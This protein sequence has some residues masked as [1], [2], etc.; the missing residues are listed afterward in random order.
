MDDGTLN[1]VPIRTPDQRLRVFVSST[2]EELADER[3]A[4][5]RA[6]S[7]LRLTPVM[8]ES[9]ARPHVP[10][11]LYQAYLAQSDI[12]IGLYWER[13]GWVAPE[14]AVSG[15]EDEFDLSSSLPRL[16]YIR[17][18]APDRD[19]RLVDLI[20]RIAQEASYRTFRTPTELGRL[21]RDDLATLLSERFAAARPAAPAPARD[22]RRLPVPTT[23]LVGRD[24]DLDDIAALIGGPGARLV[25]LTGPPGI[26]KT[27]LAIAAGQRVGDRF[28]AGAV[29]GA[30]SGVTEPPRA[31]NAIG[32]AVGADLT[33][34]DSPLQAL[35]ERIH[36]ESCLL[37]L[38]NLE[39]VRDVAVDLNTVLEACPG[40]AMLATSLI[41][42]RLRAEREYPVLPLPVRRRPPPT[43]AS[44]ARR[45][46]WRCS[47]IGLAPC[48]P[49]SPSPLTTRQRWWRSAAPGG[50]PARDRA[51][52][53]P[54][55]AAE[56]GF[57]PAP[58]GRVAGRGGQGHRRHAR[59]PPD[60]AGDRRVERRPARR[61][62]TIVA[63]G[64]RRV[65]R[66]LDGRRRRRGGRTPGGRRPRPDRRTGSA[67]PHR[68]RRH[69]A[70]AA[71]PDARD[72]PSLRRRVSGRPR[73]R[74]GYPAP[75]RR[76]L[77]CAHRAG[78][79]ARTPHRPGRMDR[80]PAHRGRE[81]G[82]VSALAP[83]A[84][85]RGPANL[86]RVLT[87]FWELRDP[88]GDRRGWIA[89]LR[90]DADSL[91][92]Q[93]RAELLWAG[94]MSALD[95]GDGSTSSPPPRR[96]A[97]GSPCS[98]P[99][100]RLATVPLIRW[101]WPSRAISTWHATPT[102]RARRSLSRH[103]STSA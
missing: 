80:A 13:Y 60:P 44:C 53:G 86:F 67:Q 96:S 39:D 90:P 14:S 63:R 38:D 32:R 23:S 94:A 103:A 45:P 93:P 31:V 10:Q 71:R 91:D 18:P 65:R 3:R 12:F 26:G 58:S 99:S 89:E 95:A 77:P 92:P 11:R 51:R 43:S 9:G 73:R 55:A 4:V 102:T 47:W 34:A 76:A 30:L 52:S 57:T 54:N 29:F 41:A 24:D 6:I 40:V 59:A 16:L 8:F 37:I 97:S 70:G 101:T 50:R 48:V 100:A 62:R 28:D 21:V 46:P 7:A 42:L 35:I 22:R 27:R 61:R 85:S 56:P 75:P 87:L 17:T 2:L 19:P 25:T 98:R 66:R 68:A 84:R 5:A 69:R 79:P 33:W 88:I 83:V 1:D 72:H 64:P 49:T 15:V 78:R 82:R 20:A 74:G 81:H 36:D